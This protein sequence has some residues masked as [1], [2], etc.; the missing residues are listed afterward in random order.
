MFGWLLAVYGGTT[1][2]LCPEIQR[3]SGR[4]GHWHS[5]YEYVLGVFIYYLNWPAY[6]PVHSCVRPSTETHQLRFGGEIR[7]TVYCCNP[8]QMNTRIGLDD[9]MK[10]T[11]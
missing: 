2:R 11:E 10:A 8:I 3:P 4:A 1:D 7:G 9:S 6:S 5:T